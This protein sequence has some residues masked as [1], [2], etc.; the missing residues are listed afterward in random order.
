MASDSVIAILDQEN[1]DGVVIGDSMGGGPTGL[2]CALSG[3]DRIVS[4]HSTANDIDS[5]DIAITGNA[6]DRLN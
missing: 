4:V 6:L 1:L 5:I 3:S 2:R